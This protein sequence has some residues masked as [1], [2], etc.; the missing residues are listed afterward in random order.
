MNVWS[1]SPAPSFKTHVQYTHICTHICIIQV[2]QEAEELKH[3]LLSQALS[4]EVQSLEREQEQRAAAADM[5]RRLAAAE[6]RLEE[7]GDAEAVI[8]GLQVRVKGFGLGGWMD[9]WMW[10]DVIP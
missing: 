2:R 1:F 4:G 3:T 5:A 10:G 7:L 6:R 9:G 8:A